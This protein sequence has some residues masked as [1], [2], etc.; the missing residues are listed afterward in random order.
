M[1]VLLRGGEGLLLIA[2]LGWQY[3]AC[4]LIARWCEPAVRPWRRQVHRLGARW[5]A[6]YA[7]RRG[8]LLIKLG[9]YIASRPDFFPLPY[10][11]ACAHLRDQAPPRAL[12]AMLPTLERAFEG[13]VA[14]HLAWIDPT[15]L[16]SASFGQVHHARTAC[17]AAVA[18]KIQY[19][20][21]APAVAMDLRLTRLAL[22][23]FQAMYPGWPLHLVA[24]E[25]TRTARE[26]QD[27]L[28][29]GLA[30][31]RLRP[32]LARRG[33]RAPRVLWAHTR[34]RVLVMEFAPGAT[35]AR[36]VGHVPMPERKGLAVRVVD[37]WLDMLVDEGLVHGDPHAGNL[38]RSPDG[39]TWVIDF[40]MTVEVGAAE[41]QAYRRF[42]AR[43]G[44]DDVD[45][46]VDAL[47]ELG[48]LVPGADRA[49]L[50]RLAR[51]IYEGLGRLNPLTFKGSLRQAALAAKAGSFLRNCRGIVFPRH[52]VV[53]V[54][55]LGLVEGL[56]LEL[57]PE[58]TLVDIAR[59]RLAR[60]ASPLALA[61]DAFAELRAFWNRLRQVPD[62][63]DELVAQR[64]AG[65]GLGAVLAAI[66][67]LAALQLE[68]GTARTI[69]VAVA[70]LG[71]LLGLRK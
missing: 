18:V 50:R 12:A 69:A 62:R 46:M 29:E 13:R 59:P 4:A 16:A 35:L 43:L 10:V 51:E 65:V 57:D 48:V 14:D 30:S 45:G 38:I 5:L 21:L 28:H 71:V 34:E 26:E 32:L 64:P 44:Q 56:C 47:A 40:G 3:A 67:L 19:P 8:A 36:G 11:D 25:V 37:A 20:D 9:Q 66:L 63:I 39:T 42:L 31:D 53:L 55:A 60:L 27:Y 6:S 68:P 2:W 15:P 49:A 52:T 1:G 24:E 54:R 7:R 41:R 33:L 61:S 23:L 22:R 70:G 58:R 17:G